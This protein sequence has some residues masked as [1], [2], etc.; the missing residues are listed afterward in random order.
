MVFAAECFNTAVEVAVDLRGGGLRIG[1]EG[2]EAPVWMTGPAT[3]VFDGYIELG[4]RP[5]SHPRWTR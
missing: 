2:G 3:H 5:W 1:W 4:D